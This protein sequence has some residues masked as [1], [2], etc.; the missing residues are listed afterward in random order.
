MDRPT[1]RPMNQLESLVFGATALIHLALAAAYAGHSLELVRSG[2]VNIPAAFVWLVGILSLYIAA[3]RM[4][5]RRRRASTLLAIAAIALAFAS[6]KLGWP[7]PP[8][9]IAGLGSVL[10]ALGWVLI[11]P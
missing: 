7:Y 1:E 11:R 6:F 5:V 2:S 4:L 10:A 8:A 3:V 9:V